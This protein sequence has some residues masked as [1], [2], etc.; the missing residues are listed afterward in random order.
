M[1][2]LSGSGAPTTAS[3][4][5]D[6][7]CATRGGPSAFASRQRRRLGAMVAHARRRSPFYAELYRGLPGGN[8]VLER[9]PAVTKPQLMNRFDDWVT[10]PAVTRAGVEEFVADL[11]NI[12]VDLL[13]R[14]VVVTTS[15]STGVP[16]LIDGPDQSVVRTTHDKL[17]G[18]VESFAG[19][20]L[21]RRSFPGDWHRAHKP[22]E[23]IWRPTTV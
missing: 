7:W 15:G 22:E 8:P 6:A 14:Y 11:D 18:H 17:Q 12:G 9:L 1:K 4:A 19:G 3:V 5:W 16:T 21:R 20:T 13:G 23:S 2:A 10:D